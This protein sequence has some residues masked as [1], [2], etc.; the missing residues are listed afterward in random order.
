MI[1]LCL[2]ILAPV[3]IS[4]NRAYDRREDF[5]QQYR[6]YPLIISAGFWLFIGTA[7]LYT[8]IEVVLAGTPEFKFESL[9]ELRGSTRMVAQRFMICIVMIFECGVLRHLVNNTR[10]KNYDEQQIRRLARKAL[11]VA[12]WVNLV[13]ILYIYHITGDP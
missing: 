9:R 10:K 2:I 5:T 4:A 11:D 6:N 8:L 7:I 1:P 13:L 12:F 3:V